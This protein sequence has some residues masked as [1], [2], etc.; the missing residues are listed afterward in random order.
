MVAMSEADS[1]NRQS[2]AFPLLT[3]ISLIVMLALGYSVVHEEVSEC[4]PNQ[5]PAEAFTLI[6][7][8]HTGAPLS[9]PATDGGHFGN[10]ENELPQEHS[11]YYREYTVVTPGRNGRGERRLVTGGGSPEDPDVYYYTWDHYDTF[12]EIPESDVE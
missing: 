9:Y 12:C 7:D 4:G 1:T 10:Y 3:V 5:V 2:P 6:D 11:N 8:I